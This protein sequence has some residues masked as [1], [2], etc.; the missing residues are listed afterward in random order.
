MYEIQQFPLNCVSHFA[1]FDIDV[2]HIWQHI[3]F[4]NCLIAWNA[5]VC[6]QNVNLE[7]RFFFLQKDDIV[8]AAGVFRII[9][10]L[11]EKIKF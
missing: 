9:N 1:L 6:N 4:I 5:L 10:I 2:V 3:G 8:P 11:I 7:L